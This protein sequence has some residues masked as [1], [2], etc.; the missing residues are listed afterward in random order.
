MAA[1]V[2]FNDEPN[3]RRAEVHDVASC[4]RRRN[5]TPSFRALS[6]DQSRASEGVRT[7]RL[8]QA[9]CS[10]R[11]AFRTVFSVL[12]SRIA[13][14]PAPASSQAQ[15]TR[16]RLRAAPPPLS[17]RHNGRGAQ[18]APSR[19]AWPDAGAGGDPHRKSDQ[20]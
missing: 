12:R 3:G 9:H 4:Q 17:A 15:L 11:S 20:R 2:D 6:A 1:A 13:E 8:T 10:S 7:C 5:C 18:P 14:P 19:E 16:R